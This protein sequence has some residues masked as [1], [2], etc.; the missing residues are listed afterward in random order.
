MYEELLHSITT[1]TILTD[2][3]TFR[4][5]AYQLNTTK[6]WKND[7]ANKITNLMWLSK[8]YQLYEGFEGGKIVG[9]DDEALK[10]LLKCFL[11]PTRAERAAPVYP[12][13]LPIRRRVK[14]ATAEKE[15]EFDRQI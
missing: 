3:Q 1:Q 15:I 11:L 9:F 7:E 2:G 14:V 4:F 8:P 12:L 5:G 6:L 13:P 10:M